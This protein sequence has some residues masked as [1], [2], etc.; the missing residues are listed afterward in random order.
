MKPEEWAL[1]IG[2]HV[3]PS[4]HPEMPASGGAC[5]GSSNR[6]PRGPFSPGAHGVGA[7]VALGNRPAPGAT[8]PARWPVWAGGGPGV[9]V[10]SLS[11]GLEERVAGLRV[12]PLS[13]SCPRPSS[14]GPFQDA[15]GDPTRPEQDPSVLSPQGDPSRAHAPLPGP[16]PLPGLR[17]RRA[18]GRGE[19]RGSRGRGPG[20]V[21]AP[22]AQAHP[23]P[24]GEV[25]HRVLRLGSPRPPGPP[26]RR[27]RS[28]HRTFGTPD[29]RLSQAGGR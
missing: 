7:A 20:S 28:G 9:S 12:R 18:Q 26:E 6:K 23:Q 4:N 16:P 19:R 13:P 29:P 11:S 21:A 25:A 5:S 1:R 10:C 8:T 27:S 14:P 2:A 15:P 22:T 24:W 17:S 3:G